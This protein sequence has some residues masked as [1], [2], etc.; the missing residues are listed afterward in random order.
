MILAENNQRNREFDFDHDIICLKC[1]F[2]VENDLKGS[3]DLILSPS[4][5]EKIQIMARKVCL[6]C[7]GKT[8][9]DIVNKL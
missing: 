4:S 7:K 2:R 9:L 3:L 8:L 5:S 1:F 6:M